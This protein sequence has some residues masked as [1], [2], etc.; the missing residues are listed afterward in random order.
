MKNLA[1]GELI[2][3][4]IEISKSKNKANIGIKGSIIDETKNMLIIKNKIGLKKN[5]QGT[6]HFHNKTKR[7]DS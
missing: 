4:N 7:K 2:G 1:K 6:K 5:D 3:L